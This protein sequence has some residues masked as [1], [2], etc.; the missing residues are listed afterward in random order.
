LSPYSNKKQY[1]ILGSTVNILA[2]GERKLSRNSRR[3]RVSKSF[4]FPSLVAVLGLYSASSPSLLHQR[5]NL[6]Y[7]INANRSFRLDLTA[8][9]VAYLLEPQWNPMM[10]EQALCRIHRLGQ[11][12]DVKTIR[13]RIKGSFEEVSVFLLRDFHGLGNADFFCRK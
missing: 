5:F 12:K 1:R 9:S 11:H 3:M 10:E 7:L 8:A 6:P 13:Y 2:K 4:L